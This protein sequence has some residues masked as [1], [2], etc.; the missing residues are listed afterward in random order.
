MPLRLSTAIVGTSLRYEAMLNQS[1]HI[2]QLARYLSQVETFLDTSTL[3]LARPVMVDQRLQD[4]DIQ[5]GDRLLIFLSPPK[6]VEFP[7]PLRPGD[8]IITIRRGD[9]VVSSRG[10]HSVL[11]G[12]PD[13]SQQVVPDIDLR[14][15]VPPDALDYISRNCLWLSVDLTLQQWYATR[16]GRTRIMVDD[17]ELGQDA[18][19]LNDVHR[20]RF[21]RATD[22]PLSTAP[23]AELHLAVEQVRTGSELLEGI[24]TGQERMEVRVGTE[25]EGQLLNASESLRLDQIV[26]RLARYNDITL[27][28]ESSVY[29]TRLLAPQN[30]LSAL[31]SVPDAFLY[32]AVGLRHAY[33]VLHLYDILDRTRV[34]TVSA[35]RQDDNKVIGCRMNA[36]APD[37]ALNIDLYDTVIAL[38]YDPRQVVMGGS[39][40]AHIQYRAVE[41][42]WF[43]QPAEWTNAPLY[44]NNARLVGSIPM[45]LT[46]GDVLTFGPSVNHFYSRL[47]IEVAARHSP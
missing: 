4:L 34:Y 40:Q 38:G 44:L 19:P 10:K 1:V 36:D 12:K 47:E 43:I 15:L 8:K 16:S 39:V 28:P 46:T 37:P 31:N 14:Y 18:V 6:T 13:E 23:I 20:L 24:E 32:S 17:L 11:V 9:R 2:G 3:E 30:T 21:Y 29:L 26:L 27:P 22:N 33:S 41:D 5:T 35:L 42:T 45:R 25:R 7:A